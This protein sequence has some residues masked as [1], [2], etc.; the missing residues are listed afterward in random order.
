[1]LNGIKGLWFILKEKK[2]G[3]LNRI[4]LELYLNDKPE[5]SIKRFSNEK[6]PVVLIDKNNII[7][8]Y[9]K[10][11]LTLDQAKLLNKTEL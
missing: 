8:Q 7:D 4:P 10:T 1:M 5:T 2:M 3:D 6:N 9:Y 11:Q